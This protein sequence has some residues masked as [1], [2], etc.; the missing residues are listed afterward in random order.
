MKKAA[1]LLLFVILSAVLASSLFSLPAFANPM[2]PN[3]YEFTSPENNKVYSSNNV[4]A[5]ISDYNY[6]YYNSPKVSYVLDNQAPVELNGTSFTLTNLS[7]GSHVLT[8]YANEGNG[9][10]YVD[11]VYFS[12]YYSTNML[13]FIVGF[14]VATAVV[15]AG[16]LIK[17]EQVITRLR[18]KKSAVFWM[19]LAFF[20]IGILAFVPLA[21]ETMNYFGVP[22]YRTPFIF[23]V[24]FLDVS[25]I[26][27][28]GLAIGGFFLMLRGTRKKGF[29]VVTQL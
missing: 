13:L 12:V 9:A 23:F 2:A 1:N 21:W 26:I 6:G 20:T 8:L 16:F 14:A 29:E 18:N 4:E 7:S 11:K 5:T 15:S 3:M 17:R 24:F 27:S 22:T 28:V 19:G 10:D 25:T